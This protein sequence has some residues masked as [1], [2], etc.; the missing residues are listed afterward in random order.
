[1]VVMVMDTFALMLGSALIQT[2]GFDALSFAL[3]ASMGLLVAAIWSANLRKEARTGQAVDG[4]VLIKRRWRWSGGTGLLVSLLTCWAMMLG[5]S[6]AEWAIGRAAV[7]SFIFGLLCSAPP[8]ALLV[9]FLMEATFGR[10]YI[11]S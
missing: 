8:T 4:N 6:I 10:L 1:M 3:G 11:L 7:F 2:E 9:A 5:L